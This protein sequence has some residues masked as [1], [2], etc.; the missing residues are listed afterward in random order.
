MNELRRSFLS[1]LV[2]KIMLKNQYTSL[3]I[4]YINTS[5]FFS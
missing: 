2:L 1:H 3:V 4:G 5:S